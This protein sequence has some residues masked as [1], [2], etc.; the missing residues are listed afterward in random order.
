MEVNLLAAAG[1]LYLLPRM[2]CSDRMKRRVSKPVLNSVMSVFMRKPDAGS[3]YHHA[4]MVAWPMLSS[5]RR[6]QSDCRSISP[7]AGIDDKLG[8]RAR[9]R[10]GQSGLAIQMP[11]V[12]QEPYRP[13]R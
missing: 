1:W 9:M 6:S 4:A 5:S 2:C 3:T 10:L 8:N 12:T 11:Q 13:V 7:N